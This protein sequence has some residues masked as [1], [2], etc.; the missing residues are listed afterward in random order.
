MKK[1]LC[2][3]PALL[4]F[5]MIGAPNAHADSYTATFACENVPGHSC[6]HFSATTTA[7]FPG[8][9]DLTVTLPFS[10]LPSFTINLPSSDAPTDTYWWLYG[11]N[12]LAIQGM[13]VGGFT[14][15]DRTTGLNNRVGFSSVSP[16]P[17]SDDISQGPLTFTPET[18]ATPEPASV[19]LMLLGA[20]LISFVKRERF[21][22]RIPRTA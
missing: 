12:Q 3:I 5:A 22:V 10:S 16:L 11:A 1:L 20:G 7:S 6:F 14:V 19:I 2:V 9:T 18:S 13:Y 15:E 17:Y 4:L 21:I 8:P